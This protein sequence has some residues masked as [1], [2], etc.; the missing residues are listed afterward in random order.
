VSWIGKEKSMKK[1]IDFV[2]NHPGIVSLIG[3]LLGALIAG[4][5]EN[6]NWIVG[7]FIGWAIFFVTPYIL[8]FGGADFGR[9][10]KK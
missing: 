8:I 7:M 9:F 2:I 6:G 5:L 3:A 4:Q 10:Q 1:V